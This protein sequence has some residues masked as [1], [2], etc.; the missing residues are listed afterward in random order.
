MVEPIPTGHD[1]IRVI[2]ERAIALGLVALLLLGVMWVL[3]PFA[4]A[5][6]LGAFITI[7]IWPL[8]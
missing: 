3:Q 1:H 4:K 2:I 8:R 7:A 5:I 6:L